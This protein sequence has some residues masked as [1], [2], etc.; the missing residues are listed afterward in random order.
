MQKQL[1]VYN[2]KRNCHNMILFDSGTFFF[3]HYKFIYFREMAEESVFR[4]LLEILM[5][6]SSEIEQACKGSCEFVDLDTCL[7]LTAEC[8]RCLRNA[9]VECAKNQHVMRYSYDPF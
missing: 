4:N 3:V 7:L 2:K 1:R 9:C 5:S 6:A 8:F